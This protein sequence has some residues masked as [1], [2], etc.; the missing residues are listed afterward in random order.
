V[1][2]WSL[3]RLPQSPALYDGARLFT[4]VPFLLFEHPQTGLVWG[5]SSLNLH[6]PDHRFSL[7]LV[8]GSFDAPVCGLSIEGSA[9]HF[10]R[11]DHA[12]HWFL[13]ESFPYSLRALSGGVTCRGLTGTSWDRSS[14][15]PK[16][17]LS[18]SFKLMCSGAAVPPRPRPKTGFFDCPLP[19]PPLR[20]PVSVSSNRQYAVTPHIIVHLSC[21]ALP[22]PIPPHFAVVVLVPCP[23][24][25]AGHTDT[26]HRALRGPGLLLRIGR[27]G[28]ELSI[29]SVACEKLFPSLRTS[30]P[31]GEKRTGRKRKNFVPKCSLS[32][33][34]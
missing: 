17:V 30:L 24:R 14:A 29:R 32:C 26:R 6:C 28:V 15:T 23:P 11:G 4:L 12:R 8:S 27:S 25:P 16:L 33:L 2:T 19:A 13:C 22:P 5:L 21:R 34:R 7:W 9:S 18:T 10:E 1:W 3:R 20:P 31:R